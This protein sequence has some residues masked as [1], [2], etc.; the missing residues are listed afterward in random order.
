M[1][2]KERPIQPL[3]TQQRKHKSAGGKKTIADSQT[4]DDPSFSGRMAED[5]PLMVSLLPTF[6][7]GGFEKFEYPA[8][9]PGEIP[10]YRGSGGTFSSGIF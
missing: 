5:D 8:E 4:E 3:R 1:E 9:K 10:G 7:P 2:E 6:N